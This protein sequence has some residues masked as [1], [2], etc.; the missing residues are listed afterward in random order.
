M[1]LEAELAG[2]DV[3]Q[4]DGGST[5]TG[6]MK[7][8]P[9]AVKKKGE[10]KEGTTVTGK[11]VPRQKEGVSATGLFSFRFSLFSFFLSFFLFF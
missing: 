3:S 10:T 4:G 7:F 9:S 2:E 6:R 1:Q 11:N 8:G 5:H